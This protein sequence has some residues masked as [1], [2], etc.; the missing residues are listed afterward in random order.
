M[1]W[2]SNI[3]CLALIVAAWAGATSAQATANEQD[4]IVVTGNRQQQAEVAA[5]Q[6]A[7]ITLRT[8]ADNPLP[9]HYTPICVKV[10][11]IDQAFAEVLGERVMENARRLDLQTGKTGCQPNVWIGFAFNSKAEVEKLRRQLPEMFGTF[12][13]VEVERIFRGSGAAQAWHSTEV[14]NADGR[15]MRYRTIEVFG[16]SATVKSTDQYRSGRLTSPI[17]VDIN[18]TIVVFDAARA[19]GRTILQLADYAT[20]RILAPVQ[21]FDKMPDGGAPSILQLFAEEAASVD[22]LTEFDWAYLS[23]FYKLDRGATASAVHDATRKAMLDG[24]GQRLREKSGE[25]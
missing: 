15:P 9:R 18:G 17:R 25:P 20:M 5:E 14:R 24:T 12:S 23:A 13:K 21:D 10:F 19:Q 2:P 1:R 3:T 22:G 4:A 16:R 11:G 6:A 8:L 7:A